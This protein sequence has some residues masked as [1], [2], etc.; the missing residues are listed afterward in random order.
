MLR[1]RL[2]LGA[3][4]IAGLVVLFWLDARA[5]TPGMYLLPLALLLSIVAT[6]EL[7]GLF[8]ARGLRTNSAVVYV[9]NFLIVLANFAGLW[10][11]EILPPLGWAAV[12]L[13][14]CIGLAFIAEM[15]H[16]QAPG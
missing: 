11:T 4:F 8:A 9:G 10:L 14:I 2:L 13:G 15:A 1:W 5:S 16:Y 7:L 12:A 6:E 3:V